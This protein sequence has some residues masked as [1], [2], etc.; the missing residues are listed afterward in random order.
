LIALALDA[1]QHKAVDAPLDGCFAVLGAPASGKSTALAERLARARAIAPNADPLAFA[2]SHELDAFA[3]ELLRKSGA[4]ITLV[5]DVEAALIFA[6]AA[7]PLLELQW[8][9][10]AKDQLD[11]EIPGLRSPERFLH[12]AFRLIRRLRDAAIEPSVFLTD[13]LTGA[14]EFYANPPNLADPALLYATKTSYHDSLEA[15]PAELQRQ[16]RREID[17]AKILAKLYARYVELVESSGQMT[18]RDAAIAAARQLR[19]DPALALRLRERHGYA[20]IDDAQDLTQAQVDLLSALFGK[21]LP[22][23]TFCGDPRSVISASRM[24]AEPFALAQNRVELRAKYRSAPH[25]VARPASQRDEAATIADRVAAWL[26]QGCRPERI[27]VLFRS[28]RDVQLYE[29]ALLE[30]D[31]PVVVSGDVNP[32]SDRRALDA[33]ALL[34]NVYD[35]FR[36]DWLLRTLGNPGVGLSDASL[37][38]L[39]A[40]PP[41][42]Q[43]PLFAL[44]EEP[45]PTTRASRWNPKRDLRLGWNVVRGEQDGALPPDAAARLQ[46]FR[47][48]REGW[49]DAVDALPFED[50]VRRVWREGL[51]RDGD[52]ASARARAQQVALRRLLERLRAYVAERPDAGLAEVLTYAEERTF[53]DLE[54]CVD[55]ESGA[56]FVQILSVEAARGRG[57]DRVVVAD[58]RAGAFPRYYVPDAF[59]FS[60]RLGM[61]PKE[62]VGEAKA[63]RTAKFSY[64]VVR[65]K[66]AK[67]YYERERRAFAYALSRARESVLVTAS[68]TPTRGVTAPEFLEELR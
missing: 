33:L 45:A 44:D 35:P 9:E 56:G 34:W 43:R 65:T 3:V 7:S 38:T 47:R 57:F 41:D 31:V 24:V 61:I 62:N 32:F 59:L 28:V 50:F 2:S 5:D 10:F 19:A 54:T 39:C 6:R 20:F 46:R 1:E 23:V 27:A 49:I 63:S 48:L 66:A 18:G 26:A 60:R 58:A 51:A 55:D 22:G 53:S 14:T 64:Y 37:A 29:T 13:A 42:P 12:S 30:R 16:Y 4:A 15:T 36:H 68:G 40:E 11:P 21:A 25:E 8:D 52:P 67:R 17:L